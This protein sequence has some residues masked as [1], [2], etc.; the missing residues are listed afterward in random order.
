MEVSTI[1]QVLTF[2]GEVSLELQGNF[3]SIENIC[4]DMEVSFGYRQLNDVIKGLQLL[5]KELNK[6]KNRGGL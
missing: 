4:N 1:K 6:K 5:K 2:D 3:I